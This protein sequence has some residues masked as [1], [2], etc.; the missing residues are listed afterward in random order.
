MDLRPLRPPG[1]EPLLHGDGRLRREA[2]LLARVAVP[3]LHLVLEIPL[4]SSVDDRLPRLR[5]SGGVH[6]RALPAPNL[7]VE[8]AEDLGLI[9]TVFIPVHPSGRV[10]VRV[11]LLV[12][13]DKPVHPL[14]VD[15]RI[16][17]P[18]EW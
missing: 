4:V 8:R 3:V 18:P 11:S 14:R 1:P 17:H 13:R 5:G 16:G 2:A 9:T 7:R 10:R 15:S 6:R 12:G